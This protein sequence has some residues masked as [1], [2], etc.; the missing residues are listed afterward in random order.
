MVGNAVKEMLGL[1]EKEA[2]A[3]EE[4]HIL[5]FALGGAVK[6]EMVID[7]VKVSLSS[8]VVNIHFLR[9]KLYGS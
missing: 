1:I 8:L 6:T 5:A 4:V 3:K 9:N 2:E 7:K